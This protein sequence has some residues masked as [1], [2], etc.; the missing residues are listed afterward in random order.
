MRR[1]F[2]AAAL[3]VVAAT[4]LPAQRADSVLVGARVRVQL[5]TPPF[6]G[7]APRVEG[8]F[9]ASDRRSLRLSVPPNAEVRSIERNAIGKLERYEGRRSEGKAFA[10]GAARGAIAGGAVGGVLVAAAFLDAR[11]GCSDCFID[12]RAIAGVGA[13]ALTAAGA[14]IGGAIGTAFRDRWT[15]VRA[16]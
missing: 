12:E 5:L 1:I 7:P 13:V 3:V 11:K 15:A 10:R 14:L 6:G 8:R 16:Y 9:V 4:T 2:A